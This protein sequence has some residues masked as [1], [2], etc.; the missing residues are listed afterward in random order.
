MN[1][2]RG[3]TFVAFVAFCSIPSVPHRDVDSDQFLRVIWLEHG[4]QVG[5]IVA[6]RSAS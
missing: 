2:P 4:Q 5:L 3:E 1:A 6:R